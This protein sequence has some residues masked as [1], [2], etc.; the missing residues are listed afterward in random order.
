MQNSSP[1]KKPRYL[2]I[3]VKRGSCLCFIPPPPPPPQKK[4]WRKQKKQKKTNNQ[5][6]KCYPFSC[7]IHR[8]AIIFRVRSARKLALS[9]RVLLRHL[10]LLVLLY[11]SY[12]TSW[13]I[14]HPPNVETARTADD[15]KYER[16]V[17][18]WFDLTI[19]F[20]KTIQ[21]YSVWKYSFLNTYH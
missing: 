16:C 6:L 18:N 10:S 15:L 3:S 5:M 21:L 14:L 11:C 2:L 19:I 1:V 7:E 8:V 13:T 20:G 9:D 12:L 17:E 4:K